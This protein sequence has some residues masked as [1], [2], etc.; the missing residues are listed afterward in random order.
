MNGA[1][2]VKPFYGNIATTTNIVADLH[3]QARTQDVFANSILLML[4]VTPH[5]LRNREWSSHAATIELSPQQNVAATNQIHACSLFRLHLLS[6]INKYRFSSTVNN[7]L[8]WRQ[9]ISCSMTRPLVSLWLVRLF[10]SM[11]L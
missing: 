4:V 5:H 2:F 6:W 1:S 11:L 9:L 3:S 10:T 7:C 8:L